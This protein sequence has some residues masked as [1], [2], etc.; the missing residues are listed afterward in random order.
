MSPSEIDSVKSENLKLRN[1]ISLV[2]AEIELS[3]RLFE[4]KQNFANS[5]DSQRLIVPILDRISKI[6]SEKAILEI[7]LKLN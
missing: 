3:Q 5:A 7:E 1:Y 6:K 2:S 4:I